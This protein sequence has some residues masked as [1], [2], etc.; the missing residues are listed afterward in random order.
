MKQLYNCGHLCETTIT[1]KD[2]PQIH[3]LPPY[4]DTCSS[5]GFMGC[6]CCHPRPRKILVRGKMLFPS[7]K[8]KPR[9]KPYLRCNGFQILQ[10]Y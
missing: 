5:I 4:H 2:G 1:I 9:E 3:A 7:L 10:A 8:R 6:V